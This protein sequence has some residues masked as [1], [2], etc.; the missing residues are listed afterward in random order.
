MSNEKKIT[1]GS[2]EVAEIPEVSCKRTWHVPELRKSRIQDR[3]KVGLPGA[4]N[5]A[6]TPSGTAVS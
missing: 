6:D 1:C 4:I 2:N 5:D 3:T